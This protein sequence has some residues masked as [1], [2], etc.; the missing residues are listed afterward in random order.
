MNLFNENVILK[1][2]NSLQYE[3]TS[4]KLNP[5]KFNKLS[6]LIS[7]VKSK[8]TQPRSFENDIRDTLLAMYFMAPMKSIK[9]LLI[10]KGHIPAGEDNLDF[11]QVVGLIKDS[12]LGEETKR[13]LNQSLQP[14]PLGR[15]IDIGHMKL[16]QEKKSMG[17]HQIKIGSTD[18]LFA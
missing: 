10:A 12:M 14:F 8:V 9:K 1:L 7:I 6:K 18:P 16:V 5:G 17:F 2:Y 13:G 15:A 11:T 4:A 3:Y